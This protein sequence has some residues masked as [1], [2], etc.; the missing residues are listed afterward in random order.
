MRTNN[1]ITAKEAL[2]IAGQYGLTY[3]VETFMELGYSP[4]EALEEW[5]LI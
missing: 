3:E 1:E 2:N 4:I 5:D